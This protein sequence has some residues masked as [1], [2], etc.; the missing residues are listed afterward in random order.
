[1]RAG[2]SA[3]G[4]RAGIVLGAT[5]VLVGIGFLLLRLFDVE[6]EFFSWPLFIVIP[7]VLLFALALALKGTPAAWLI[8]P[9][10]IVTMTGLL[11]LY[12]DTTGHWE[13][14]AY[15]WALL[16]PGALGL[17]LLV[18]GWLEGRPLQV[19]AGM[20]LVGIGVAIFV[21]GG[22]FLELILDISGRRFGRVLFPAV[23]IGLGLLLLLGPALRAR[24]P[25]RTGTADPPPAG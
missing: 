4:R 3:Q 23:L 9:A 21:I 11:L 15:A 6:L 14:W 1:M 16:A 22:I 7:G 17:G 13:S 24:R 25:Q 10:S 12:Q 19:A 5:L 8:V 20:R 2:D 18:H